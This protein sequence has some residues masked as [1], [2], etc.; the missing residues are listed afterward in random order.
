[1]DVMSIGAAIAMTGGAATAANEAAKV[2]KNAAEEANKAAESYSNLDN[3]AVIDRTAF[4]YAYTLM[5]AEFRDVQKRLAA[6]EAKLN[7]LT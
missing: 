7:A 1:M 6:A 2:A 5:Q 3:D 4:N